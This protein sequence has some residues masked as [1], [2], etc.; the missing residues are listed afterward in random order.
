M[1][2]DTFNAVLDQVDF[3]LALTP[4]AS[5]TFYGGLSMK[6]QA[7]IRAMPSTTKS[8]N[9]THIPQ[10]HPDRFTALRSTEHPYFLFLAACQVQAACAKP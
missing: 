4:F 9:N 10:D 1:V 2:Y 5:S 6:Y 8:Q 3:P 7:T